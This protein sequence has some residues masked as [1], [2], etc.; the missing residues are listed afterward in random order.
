MRFLLATVFWGPWHG[1][2]FREAMLP[3]VMAKGNLPA[4]MEM[5]EV[6]W[7]VWSDAPVSLPCPAVAHP[8]LGGTD[9]LRYRWQQAHWQQAVDLARARDAILMLVPPDVMWTDGTLAHVGAAFR[10]GALS[11]TMNGP[12]ALDTALDEWPLYN[13]V[14]SLNGDETIRLA[15]NHPHPLMA[16]FD[17]AA[18]HACRW[19]EMVAVPL[20][21]GWLCRHFAHETFAWN[22]GNCSIARN[23]HHAVTIPPE[24]F[25]VITDSDAGGFISLAPDG[26]FSHNVGT[27]PIDPHDVAKL[28]RACPNAMTDTL[29]RRDMLW[30][31]GPVDAE[32][33]RHA[34]DRL[35][36]FLAQCRDASLAMPGRDLTR[37]PRS[38]RNLDRR[39]K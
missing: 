23:R 32:K 26:H 39:L 22:P 1:R 7:H 34:R 8:L 18:E 2:M 36:A 28:W 16:A 29:L 38:P 35:D 21:N 15:L 14:I 33:I 17:L 5:G 31:D 19:P 37:R 11:V 10:D 12:R 3:T 30:H 24:R 27:A 25:H 9:A 6:E 4:L 13:G 20:G